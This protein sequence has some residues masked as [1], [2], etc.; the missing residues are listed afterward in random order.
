VLALDAAQDAGT[1]LSSLQGTQGDA[2]WTNS[3][4]PAMTVDLHN[5]GEQAEAV[6]KN[7]G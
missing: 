5:A 6:C 1:S 3:N 2:S 7:Q 4:D